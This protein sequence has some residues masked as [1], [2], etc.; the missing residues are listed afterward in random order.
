MS[1][2]PL[3][4][5]L[6]LAATPAPAATP[7]AADSDPSAQTRALVT[8]FAAVQRVPDH[9]ADAVAGRAQGV[10]IGGG[11]LRETAR[12]LGLEAAFFKSDTRTFGAKVFFALHRGE[13][14]AALLRGLPKI[15]VNAY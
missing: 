2:L 11:D 1:L 10:P 12:R 4:A 7:V 3:L 13:R 5:S 8:A 15:F 9:L 6:A 14:V